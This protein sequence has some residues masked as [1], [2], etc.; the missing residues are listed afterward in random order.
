MYVH[1]YMY[2]CIVYSLWKILKVH[3]AIIFILWMNQLGLTE[4]E[5]TN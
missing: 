3:I 5:L 1:T 2:L 4:V